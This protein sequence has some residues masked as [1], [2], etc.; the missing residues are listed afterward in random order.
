MQW[1]NDRTCNSVCGFFRQEKKEFITIL[2]L[3]LMLTFLLSP[4]INKILKE[5]KTIKVVIYLLSW[6]EAHI[7][8][9]LELNTG[10]DITR[11]LGGRCHNDDAS[12]LCRWS[13]HCLGEMLAV[14]SSIGANS[15]LFQQLIHC[16]QKDKLMS[17][18]ESDKNIQL[19][20]ASLLPVVSFSIYVPPALLSDTANANANSAL[21][22]KNKLWVNFCFF[23]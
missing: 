20:G 17:E 12:T 19:N 22:S 13:C 1:V 2:D 4:N 5:R 23:K 16:E 8:N 7:V 11:S 10:R 18:T 3:F 6:M 15:H 21:Q 9:I 14:D